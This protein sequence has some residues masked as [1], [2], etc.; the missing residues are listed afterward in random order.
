MLHEESSFASE[1][2]RPLFMVTQVPAQTLIDSLRNTTPETR[3]PELT[4]LEG[5]APSIQKRN[6]EL[7]ILRYLQ[8]EPEPEP[9]KVFLNTFLLY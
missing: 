6:N 4:V 5:P 7:G 1:P 3:I 2:R 9:E 8:P